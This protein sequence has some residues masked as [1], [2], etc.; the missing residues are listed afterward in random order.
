MRTLKIFGWLSHFL[1]VAIFLFGIIFFLAT[2]SS[3]RYDDY[4]EWILLINDNNVVEKKDIII[5]SFFILIW[6]LYILYFIAIFLFNLSVRNFE[7]RDFYNNKHS[8][9][10]NWIGIIFIFNYLITFALSKYLIIKRPE[11]SIEITLPISEAI[12]NQ[13]QSPLGGLIIGF[14][15]LVLSQVFKEAK[16]QKEEN[17]ELKHENELTI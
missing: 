15:F 8:K 10:F 2:K 4:S 16:K 11:D 13:L 5:K 7:K 1:T 3:F 17:I 6:I 14:F 12:F 9:R